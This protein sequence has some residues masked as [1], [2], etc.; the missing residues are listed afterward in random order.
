MLFKAAFAPLA[1][2]L[3][4][5]RL[6]MVGVYLVSDLAHVLLLVGGM[7]LLLAV[8]QARD[9]PLRPPSPPTED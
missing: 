8:L 3:L 6:D 1:I 7:L 2:W 4:G 5:R 9:A